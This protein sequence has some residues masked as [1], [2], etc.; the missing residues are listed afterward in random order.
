MVE[1][2]EHANARRRSDGARERFVL[3]AL[4][5]AALALR[6]A[7][8]WFTSLHLDDFHSLFHAR[9][10]SWTEFFV[11][12]VRDNH[13][14]LSFALLRVVRALVG[15]SELLLRVPALLAGVLCVPV[16][17]RLARRAGDGPARIFATA[18]V[19]ASS[20]HLELSSDLRMYALLALAT[21]G[22]V[23]AVCDVLEGEGGVVRLAA[24]CTVGLHTHYHFVHALLVIGGTALVLVVFHPRLRAARS[25][26]L[27]GFAAAALL[28]TPWFLFGFREQLLGH[29]LAP[30]GSSV[31]PLRFLESLVHLVYLNIGLAGT[32]RPLVLFAGALTLVAAGCGALRLARTAERLPLVAAGLGLPVWS[33][34]FAL[35]FPR[36]GFEWRYLAGAIVPFTVLVAAAAAGPGPL[37]RLRRG[38]AAFLV[39][40]AAGLAL[41]NVP[42]PGGENYAG[43]VRSILARLRPGDAVVAA[44][45]QPRLFPHS[46]GWNWYAPRLATPR[47]ALPPLLEHT[48]DFALAAGVEL[49][50][51]ERVFVIGRSLPTDVPLFLRLRSAFDTE[52]AS[53]FGRSV[54]VVLFS[55]SARPTDG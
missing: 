50:R 31:T 41:A 52:Q 1:P 28:S 39:V 14:P 3:L 42:D 53:V 4:V 55:R 37:L 18:L 51:Y 32:L 44:D 17:W 35:A 13:P 20:L 25:G 46:G 29:D 43:G 27:R 40:A 24:W 16:A 7:N 9:A 23:D 38:L 22:F 48:D 12:L 2:H 21:A 15:E 54:W 36:G 30:G 8:A 5:A 11:M 26:L 47:R 19:A 10:A 45:W 33:A 6:V 49:E 34:A